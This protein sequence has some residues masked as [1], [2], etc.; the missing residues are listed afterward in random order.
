MQKEYLPTGPSRPACPVLIILLLH[1]KFEQFCEAN[2]RH[3]LTSGVHKPV[4]AN[5]NRP[6]ED[7]R[8]VGEDVFNLIF[9][10]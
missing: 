1:R 8:P 3:L 2:L 6:T 7:S 5:I 9:K 4:K 10:L